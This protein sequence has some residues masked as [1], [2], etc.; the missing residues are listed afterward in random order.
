M[1]VTVGIV[2]L[3]GPA[4][5]ISAIV[6]CAEVGRMKRQRVE[7]MSTTRHRRVLVIRWILI[8]PIPMVMRMADD[9]KGV[10]DH[11]NYDLNDGITYNGVGGFFRAYRGQKIRKHWITESSRN[12]DSSVPDMMTRFLDLV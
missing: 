2:N 11:T 7:E 1:V 4:W 10:L 12:Q 8:I 5:T 3:L 9:L 6:R